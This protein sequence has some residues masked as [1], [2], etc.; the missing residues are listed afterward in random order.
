MLRNTLVIYNYC[1]TGAS[2][3]YDINSEVNATIW[4]R[5]TLTI[6]INE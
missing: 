3:D 6:V 1:L 4:D 2:L 5:V